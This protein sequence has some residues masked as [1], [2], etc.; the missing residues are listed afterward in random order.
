MRLSDAG[1]RCRQTKAV[2]LNHRPPPWLSE[3]EARDR[4][5]R[6]LADQLV[7]VGMRTDPEPKHAAFNVLPKHPI[8][9]PNAR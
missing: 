5:N 8:L 6:L 9:V 2:Y 3:D 4:S 1:L 7:V